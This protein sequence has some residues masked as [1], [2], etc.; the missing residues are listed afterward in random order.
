MKSAVA[1]AVSSVIPQVSSRPAR[2][3]GSSGTA[4]VLEADEKAYE[5]PTGDQQVNHKAFPDN[6]DDHDYE[7]E[8]ED[9]DVEGTHRAVISPN[10][11][12]KDVQQQDKAQMQRLLLPQ[13]AP[14]MKP[15][16]IKRASTFKREPEYE[17]SMILDVPGLHM[18]DQEG[19]DE[20]E[21]EFASSS[22]RRADSV[23]ASESEYSVSA[24]EEEADPEPPQPP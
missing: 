4:T 5:I 14:L 22:T 23:S 17:S 11:L 6:K 3:P 8:L 16:P 15:S 10:N 19:D 2:K 12:S 7:L 13:P 18:E 21:M 20:M 9:S 24:G 1:A